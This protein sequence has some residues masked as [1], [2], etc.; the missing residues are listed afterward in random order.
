V[1][2]Q[3]QAK[4][5]PAGKKPTEKKE[6]ES[7]KETASERYCLK[8]SLSRGAAVVYVDLSGKTVK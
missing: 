1:Q 2:N 3:F 4:N 8:H 7:K 5:E 6:N